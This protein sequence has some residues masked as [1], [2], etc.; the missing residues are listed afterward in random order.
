MVN[1]EEHINQILTLQ[2]ALM[3]KIDA[4]AKDIADLKAV[5][6]GSSLKSTGKRVTKNEQAKTALRIDIIERYNRKQKSFKVK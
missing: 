2:N 1:Q 4:Q 6:C 3:E 5:L